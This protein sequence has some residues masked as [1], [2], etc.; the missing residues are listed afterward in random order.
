MLKHCHSSKENIF[1]TLEKL[2]SG[3]MSCRRARSIYSFVKINQRY[4]CCNTQ[5]MACVCPSVKID[6]E[7]DVL[8]SIIIGI[9]IHNY[10]IIKVHIK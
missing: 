5:L 9:G 2:T 3:F 8:G 10:F 1:S 6:N 7:I 4:L